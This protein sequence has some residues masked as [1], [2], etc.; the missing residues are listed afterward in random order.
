MLRLHVLGLCTEL[1]IPRYASVYR[2]RYVP[3]TDR[4]QAL[5]IARYAVPTILAIPSHT[6]Q[7]RAAITDTEGGRAS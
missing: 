4:A 6:E 3:N 7:Y 5:G 2:A 1:L